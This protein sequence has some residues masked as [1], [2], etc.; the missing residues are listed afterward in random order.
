MNSDSCLKWSV[1]ATGQQ[2]SPEKTQTF[3]F[4]LIIMLLVL[5]YTTQNKLRLLNMLNFFV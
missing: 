2:R 4:S 1:A 5:I 3:F